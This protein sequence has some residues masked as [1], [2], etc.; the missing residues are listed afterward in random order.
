M[1]FSKTGEFALF[2]TVFI[3]TLLFLHMRRKVLQALFLSQWNI[4]TVWSIPIMIVLFACL[5]NFFLPLNFA[6]LIILI[7]PISGHW[8]VVKKDSYC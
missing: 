6:I 2:W 8:L 1:A 4:M 5:K 3:V 7:T